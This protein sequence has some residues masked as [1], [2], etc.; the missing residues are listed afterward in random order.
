[1]LL[2]RREFV[3][4]LK[5]Y[6]AEAVWFLSILLSIIIFGI[7]AYFIKNGNFAEN[8][9]KKSGDSEF[10]KELDK[11]AQILVLKQKI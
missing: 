4:H 9:G 6:P 8:K 7:G 2:F 11:K 3:Y 5:K 1:M 10:L